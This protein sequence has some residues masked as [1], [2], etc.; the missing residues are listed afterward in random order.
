MRVCVCAVYTNKHSSGIIATKFKGLRQKHVHR[1]QQQQRQRQ[2][3]L[4]CMAGTAMDRVR[5]RSGSGFRLPLGFGFGFETMPALSLS[6]SLPGLSSS[7]C[8]QWQ[9]CGRNGSSA[10]WW[11]W[12]AAQ[13]QWRKIMK[14]YLLFMREHSSWSEWN[15][16]LCLS[17]SLALRLI[18][19]CG[20]CCC[21][22]T[23]ICVSGRV[24]S[25]CSETWKTLMSGSTRLLA[26]RGTIPLKL[27]KCAMNNPKMRFIR[28][29]IGY[30]SIMIISWGCKCKW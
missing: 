25:F 21:C 27:F 22:V 9:Q 4:H 30:G 7:P 10:R 28:K 18:L 17:R 1:I 3:M 12:W 16:M 6:R 2:Q 8:C 14:P 29:A 5:P 13:V 24:P 23:F 15:A 19:Y 20:C 26:G 11:S